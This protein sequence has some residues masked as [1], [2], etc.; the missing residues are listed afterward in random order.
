ML[1]WEMTNLR[2]VLPVLFVVQL[3]MGAGVV[4]G[5]GLLFDQVPATQ[6]LYLA[7]GATVISLLL[8]GLV[9]APQLVAAQKMAGT[10]D[11]LWSLPV[12]RVVEVLASLTVYAVVA[13]PGMLVALVVAAV[14]FDLDL[15]VSPMVIPASL[16]TVLMA[17]SVGYGFAHGIRQPMITGL[18]TQVLA[19]AIL[20]YSPI[21]FPADR[22]PG[23]YAAMHE[24]LPFQHAAAVMRDGL[25]HGLVDNVGRSYGILAVWTLAGWLVTWRVLGR[26]A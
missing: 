17:T 22:L 18:I 3:L 4:I 23:W 12:P 9:A 19:F 16:L 24:Y 21:N 11:Y 6:A 25:T 2:M 10:Y 26:R 1:R 20:L 13:L 14:R 15:V 5:F 7:T 8:I